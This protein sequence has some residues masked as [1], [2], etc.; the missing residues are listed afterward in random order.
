AMFILGFFWKRTTSNAA[1]FAT[2]GGFGLSLLL[3]ALPNMTDLSFLS[4]IGFSVKNAAGIYEIPF[5]DRMGIVF[6]FCIVG[7]VIISLFENK[8]GVNPKGLDIDAKMFKTTTSF[9]VGALII[10]GLLVA[11]YS[12]YW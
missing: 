6:V 2:I 7:M 1:L 4:G 11:L 8:N 5:L 9:A 10:V 3:K 12:V